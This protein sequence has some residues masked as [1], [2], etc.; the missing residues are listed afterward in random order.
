MK[1]LSHNLSYEITDP[2]SNIIL[3][4]RNQVPTLGVVSDELKVH[5]DSP[6]G[7]WWIKATDQLTVTFNIY[8]E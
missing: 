2:N 4:K 6:V 8:L 3:L 7:Y 1:P 5:E